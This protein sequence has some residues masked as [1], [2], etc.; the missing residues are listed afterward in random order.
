MHPINTNTD[1]QQL[2]V[3]RKLAGDFQ[4]ELCGKA[5]KP[6][7]FKAPLAD[8]GISICRFCLNCDFYDSYDSIGGK[9]QTNMNLAAAES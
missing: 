8:G 6:L 1:K 4:R 3:P 5:I 7:F 2:K 9:H